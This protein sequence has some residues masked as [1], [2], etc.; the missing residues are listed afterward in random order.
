MNNN[1]DSEDYDDA[2]EGS[3]DYKVSPE[4]FS[5]LFVIPSD[6]TVST[7]RGEIDEIVD[8]NPEFQRRSVWSPMAKSKFI[9]SL[10]LGIPIPQIL[11]AESRERRNFYLVLDGKQRLLTIKEFFE[12]KHSN[13]AAFRLTGLKD[14]IDLNGKDWQA[15]SYQF[16]EYARA[17][18][19]AQI[20]T[21]IVRGW[22]NDN[23]LYE[24]FHRLN[25]GSVRLSP[26]EL[27]MALLRGPFIASVIRDTSDADALQAMLGLKAPDKRMKDVEIAIRHMAFS[28]G[29]VIYNGNLKDF[30]DEYCRLR[31]ADCKEHGEDLT[32]LAELIRAVDAGLEIFPKGSF[33]RR[34]LTESDEFDRPFNRAAFDVLA[35]SLVNKDVRNAALKQPAKFVDL[36]KKACSNAE[37]LRSIETTTK[38]I[39]AT[40][41]RFQTW[42]GLVHNE[43]GVAL[44][45]PAIGNE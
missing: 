33:S 28:D 26:M 16:P 5:D 37:F 13:G 24:I 42:Y 10:I 22:R 40:K 1:M 18:E 45:H 9:E 2:T 32:D 25:S 6:W 41:M 12:G 3:D 17:V 23:I 36:W 29:R 44:I 19:A 31:N 30:I 39:S 34:F 11:L 27:R 4:D 15:I 14:L 35:G 38:S 7:L 43:L 21:A 20:R 8:L